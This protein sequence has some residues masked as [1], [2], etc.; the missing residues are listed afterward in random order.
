MT[1]YDEKVKDYWKISHGNCIVKMEDGKGLENEVKKVNTMPLHLGS[2]VL[3]NSKGNTKN[4]IHVINGFYTNG[5]YYGDTDS[6]YI[7]NEH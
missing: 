3:S 4:F 7:E 5:V 6:L 1:E 2:F